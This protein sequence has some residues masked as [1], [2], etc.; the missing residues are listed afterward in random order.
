MPICTFGHPS[1]VSRAGDHD[2]NAIITTN[3]V[4]ENARKPAVVSRKA[5]MDRSD[6]TGNRNRPNNAGI[7]GFDPGNHRQPASRRRFGGKVDAK[8]VAP[9]IPIALMK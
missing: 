1:S 9:V 3:E 7:K 2:E 6:N 5:V 4:P 8:E